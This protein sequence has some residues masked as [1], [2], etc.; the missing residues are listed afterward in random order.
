MWACNAGICYGFEVMRAHESPNIPF[1]VL[2]TRF[3]QGKV[4]V[5]VQK[6]K[7][8]VVIAPSTIM[9]DN[10]CNLH[11]YCLNREPQF[12][13]KSWFVVD[14]FHWRNHTGKW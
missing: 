4:C 11:N 2:Y 8:A 10:A 6:V 5:N 12:F 1:T 7:I 9:Y 3:L 14:R 13:K